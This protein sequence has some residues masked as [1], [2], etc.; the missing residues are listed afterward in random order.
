[1]N[2]KFVAWPNWL[3]RSAVAAIVLAGV[4]ISA[5]EAQTASSDSLNLSGALNLAL[6]NNPI[7]SAAREEIRAAEAEA[8]QA[9]LWDNPTLGAEVEEFGGDRGGLGDADTTLSINQTIPLGGDRGRAREAASAWALAARSDLALQRTRLLASTAQAYV[10]AQAA[11]ET[12]SLRMELLEIANNSADAIQARVEAGRASPIER[13]RAEML[14][15]LATIAANDASGAQLA[16][17]AQLVAI[18]SGAVI[19][20]E[21][22]PPLQAFDLTAYSDAQ[23]TDWIA[24]NPEL[25]QL[26]A[27]TRARGQ[28]IRRER[29]GAIPDVTVGAGVRRFGGTDETAFVATLEIPIPVVNRNQGGVA[30]AASRENAARLNEEVMRRSLI[31]QYASSAGRFARAQSTYTQLNDSILPASES[32]LGAAQEAYREGALD[33]LNF[34]DIQRSY[35]DVRVDL[36]SARAELARAAIEL[37]ALAGAPQLNRL[38]ETN[39]EEAV[40]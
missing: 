26:R 35:F 27:V 10:E 39:P 37:D 23:P 12:L 28:E 22:T 19:N 2:S 16:A 40:Q 34:L 9:G 13:N 6:E 7:T 31:A 18:W 14:V 15:G 4:S 11:S 1:M 17:N 33:V 5:A 24:N 32:A 36:I 30:A 29:A 3:G 21:L 38:V 8:L 20:G 25:V